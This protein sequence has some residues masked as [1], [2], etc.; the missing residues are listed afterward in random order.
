MNSNAPL[1]LWLRQQHRGAK[2]AILLIAAWAPFLLPRSP[3]LA[4]LLMTTATGL[5]W[6]ATGPSAAHATPGVEKPADG[7]P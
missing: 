6:L 2:F 3:L 5:F 1:I 4:G 7:E